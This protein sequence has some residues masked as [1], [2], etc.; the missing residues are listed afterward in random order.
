[1]F[2]LTLVNFQNKITKQL[3]SSYLSVLLRA[4]KTLSKPLLRVSQKI[5][6]INQKNCTPSFFSNGNLLLNFSFNKFKT[7]SQFLV[8]FIAVHNF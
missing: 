2:F 6:F 7:N 4:Q 1:M 8:L 5:Y 3:Q